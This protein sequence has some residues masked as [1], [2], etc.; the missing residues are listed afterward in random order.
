MDGVAGKRDAQSSI[1]TRAKNLA[2]LPPLKR[3]YELPVVN[4]TRLA[5]N[6]REPHSSEPTAESAR[7]RRVY[8]G[9]KHGSRV[10]RQ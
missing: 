1:A 6:D 10:G 3:V 5:R 7:D 9:S 2:K 8:R 4:K